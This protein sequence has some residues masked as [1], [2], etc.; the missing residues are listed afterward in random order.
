MINFCK[1]FTKKGLTPLCL[2]G[3]E[4]LVTVLPDHLLYLIQQDRH[5]PVFAGCLTVQD[6]VIV[7]TVF[8]QSLQLPPT[9]KDVLLN[10]RAAQ[11]VTTAEQHHGVEACAVT[12]QSLYVRHERSPLPGGEGRDDWKDQQQGVGSRS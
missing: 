7:P 10:G 2:Y 3:E 9:S 12:K 1:I 8:Q 11:P 6:V 5:T 4:G